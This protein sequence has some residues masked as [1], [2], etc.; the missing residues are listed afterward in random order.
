MINFDIKFFIISF[1]TLFTLINPIGITPIVLSLTE[2][3]NSKKYLKT[4]KTSILLAGIIL[5]TFAIMGKVI[6]SFYGITVYA[7]KIAG[8]ILFLRIGI[9]MLEA[10][11]SRTKSTPKESQEA[12][13]NNDI[14]L[15]PIGIPIIAGPG[16]ITSVMILAAETNTISH[17]IIFYMNIVITLLTTLII[18]VLAKAIS[19]KLGTTGLRVIE[20]IM[21]MILMVVAIQYIIDGLDVVINTIINKSNS[22]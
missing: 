19:K 1:S 8:G 5:F 20:R 21:G 13:D 12:I 3:F 6:F 18:L 16:A 9:N 11:I 15:T 10:K 17:K 4:I 7:F 14:A 2:N 22:I